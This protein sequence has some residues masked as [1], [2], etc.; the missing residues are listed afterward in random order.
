MKVLYVSLAVL[1]MTTL[2]GLT[3]A[4][5]ATPAANSVA[6]QAPDLS[7]I[8]V[9]LTALQ[10]ADG[11][12]Y[13]V[14][15]I[16]SSDR[17][18]PD[19]YALVA[20]PPG[21]NLV[22]ALETEGFTHFTGALPSAQGL[23]LTWAANFNAGDYVDAFTFTLDEAAVG[24]IGVNLKWGGDQPGHIEFWGQPTV[25]AASVAEN[26][27]G[28]SAAGTGDSLVPVGGTGVLVGVAPGQVPDGTKIHIRVMDP[29]EDPPATG[30]LW[31][32]SAVEVTGLP[33]G[34][35]LSVLVPL[36]SLLA[37]GAPVVLFS[38]QA[39]GTWGQ[40]AAEGIVT[41]DGQHVAYTHRG[42][43]IATGIQTRFQPKLPKPPLKPAP[44][45]PTRIPPTTRPNPTVGSQPTQI[46]VLPHPIR[47][48]IL[49][50]TPTKIPNLPTRTP[51]VPVNRVTKVL[52]P[53][54]IVTIPPPSATKAPPTPVPVR[55][56]VPAVLT[57]PVKLTLQ[58]SVTATI[59][60]KPLVPT[61][62]TVSAITCKADLRLVCFTPGGGTISLCAIAGI[63]CISTS[64]N[65]TVCFAS[66]GG[67]AQCTAPGSGVV[68][69]PGSQFTVLQPSNTPPPNVIVVVV[70]ATPVEPIP[71][72]Q[73][74]VCIFPAPS[75]TGQVLVIA[76][77]PVGPPGTITPRAAECVNL[78]ASGPSGSVEI[79]ICIDANG[80]ECVQLPLPPGVD[81]P[82]TCLSPGEPGYIPLP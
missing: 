12:R 82:F 26:D 59:G 52:P 33:A 50:G 15:I 25:L 57:V 80:V 34:A 70:T 55:P 42:G 8:A 46:P 71:T 2:F 45:T 30:D 66:N 5:S 17:A 19:L 76:P 41:F 54:P 56:T 14:T 9:Q 4:N 11:V 29:S 65:G 81:P 61:A 7:N 60:A 32:C 64:P 20:V 27:L 13:S 74:G 6:M 58:P 73:D 63:N 75:P 78:A 18:L 23:D 69:V 44:S 62:T 21:V 51:T 47:P 49:T 28:L 40:L 72:C 35:E 68:F 38:R 36:R 43:S 67:K 48:V 16:N 10:E 22:Q 39:D 24:N 3:L 53:P 1:L 79:P 77:V 31:W 37:P